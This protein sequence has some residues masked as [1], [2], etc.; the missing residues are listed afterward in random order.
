MMR[1]WQDNCTIFRENQL[2]DGIDI[3]DYQINRIYLY[4]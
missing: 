4:Y 1:V 2:P 3:S